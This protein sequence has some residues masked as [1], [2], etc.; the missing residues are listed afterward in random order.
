M[1]YYNLLKNSDYEP[2]ALIHLSKTLFRYAY[3]LE[4][5][6]IEGSFAV[7]NGLGWTIKTALIKTITKFFNLIGYQQARFEH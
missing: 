3:F 1:S 6:V 5:L 2:Q 7:K 4:G